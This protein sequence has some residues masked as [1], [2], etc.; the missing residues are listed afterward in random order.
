MVENTQ[1]PF[2]RARPFVGFFRCIHMFSHGPFPAPLLL[3]S[4]LL[5]QNTF[6]SVFIVVEPKE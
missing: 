3:E 4:P 6:F 1:P 2:W 5:T